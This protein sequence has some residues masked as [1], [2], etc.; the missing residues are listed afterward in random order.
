[1]NLYN[2]HNGYSARELESRWGQSKDY[3]TGMRCFSAKHATLRSKSKDW[4]SRTQNNVSQG[5]DMS[6]R[7]LLFWWASTIKIELSILVW[8]KV[9]I[10]IALCNLFPPWYSSTLTHSLFIMIFGGRS[11]RMLK[12]WR[13]YHSFTGL[14]IHSLVKWCDRFASVLHIWVN[15][16]ER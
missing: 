4:V 5:S 1:M 15:W 10:I 13:G 2:W 12:K 16:E 7:G 8:Y 14:N 3:K 9:S 6:T 11:A